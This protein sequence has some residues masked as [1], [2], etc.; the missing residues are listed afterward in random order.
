MSHYSLLAY[1]SEDLE[2]EKLNSQDTEVIWHWE[3]LYLSPINVFQIKLA[4]FTNQNLI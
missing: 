2:K 1:I 4:E 3:V